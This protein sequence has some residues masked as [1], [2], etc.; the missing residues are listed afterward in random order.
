MCI[1][2]VYKRQTEGL[3]LMAVKVFDA[4]MLDVYGRMDFIVDKSGNIWCLEANTL[5]GMTPTSLLPQEAAEVG[6]S[7]E[8]LCEAIISESFKK[9]AD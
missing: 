6:L 9:Y 2:D 4:L 7:Y 3:Q 8:D 5:P 1:R